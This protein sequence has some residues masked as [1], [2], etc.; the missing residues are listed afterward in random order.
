MACGGAGD[1]GLI[2][3]QW[4]DTGGQLSGVGQVVT[5]SGSLPNESTSSSTVPVTGRLSGSTIAV[6]FNGHA[7]WFGTI[8]GD[9]LT[10]NVR[11]KSGT[12]TPLTFTAATAAAYNDAVE[13]FTASVSQSN[14]RFLASQGQAGVQQVDA[15]CGTDALICPQPPGV[16]ADYQPLATFDPTTE[17][18]TVTFAHQPLEV[19]FAIAPGSGGPR[20]TLR[21]S[22]GGPGEGHWLYFGGVSPS[23]V[24]CVQDPGNDGGPQTVIVTSTGAGD[25]VVQI[26]QAIPATS[27]GG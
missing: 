21:Y 9:I 14:Y 6:S 5:V 7:E 27:T 2:F 20:E 10:L 18:Q 8:S 22:I 3:I 1:G 12:L 17:T 24:G 13:K 25:W 19:C 23:P 26:D 16:P 4:T 15:L 11:T